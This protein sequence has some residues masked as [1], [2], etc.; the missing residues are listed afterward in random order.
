[1]KL[2]H[3]LCV[4]FPFACLNECGVGLI[5]GWIEVWILFLFIVVGFRRDVDRYR[6]YLIVLMM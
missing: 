6:C 4:R 1:M 3:D 2:T 5:P